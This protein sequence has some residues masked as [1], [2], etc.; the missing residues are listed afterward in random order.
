[1]GSGLDPLR[2]NAMAGIRPA[3]ENP[4][5]LAAETK[6]RDDER[7]RAFLGKVE[8]RLVNF[9]A[10][11]PQASEPAR[12]RALVDAYLFGAMGQKPARGLARE[13]QRALVAHSM[14][15]GAGAE[16]DDEFFAEISTRATKKK[17][18]LDLWAELSTA[19]RTEALEVLGG[20]APLGYLHW[21]GKMKEK[22]GFRAD[23]QADYELAWLEERENF[24]AAVEPFAA[25]VKEVFKGIRS[26]ESDF[27][28][29]F[30]RI[31]PDQREGFKEALAAVARTLPADERPT[32]FGNLAKQAGRDLSAM[33]GDALRGVG[34]SMT[35]SEEIVSQGSRNYV[36][37]FYRAMG[38]D[39]LADQSR[40]AFA[41]GDAR[42]ATLRER[43]D[44]V[45]DVRRIAEEV[46]DPVIPVTDGSNWLTRAVEMGAYAAPGAIGTT[47]T[48][49]I[50]YA[51]PVA[52]FGMI[53]EDSYRQIRGELLRGGATE[54]QARKWAEP[55]SG[56]VAVP[57][58]ALERLGAAAVVGKLPRVNA[59]LTKLADKAGRNAL[60]RGTVRTIGGGSFETAIELTQDMM[61]PLAI[62]TAR[63]LGGDL[64]G[65]EWK[66]GKDG[67]LDDYWAKTTTT[68]VAILP[69]AILGA[70]GG[71]MRDERNRAFA[72]ASDLEL[73]AL[74][75]SETAIAEIRAAEGYQ[76][77]DAAVT[78]AVETADATTETAIDATQELAEEIENRRKALEDAQASGV[79]PIFREV[80]GEWSVTDSLTGQEIGRAPNHR[81]AIRLAAAKTLALDL[82][83]ADAVEQ[84]RID[85]LDSMLETMEAAGQEGQAQEFRPGER[86]T[87]TQAAAESVGA[88]ERIAWQ[89]RTRETVETGDSAMAD[90][91]LGSSAVEV[92]DGVRRSVNRL[93]QGA[94]ALTVLHEKTHVDF[95]RALESGA[96][97]Q[98]ETLR[99]VRAVQT[100]L[101]SRPGRKG[102]GETLA[103]HYLPADD[104]AVTL[105]HLDEAVAELV[106]AEVLRTRKQGGG[107]APAAVTRNLRAIGRLVGGKAPRF[108]AFLRAMRDHFG[109]VFKRAA[110]V[111]RALRTGEIDRAGYEGFLA[112]LQGRE[113]QQDL[114]QLARDAEA[115]ILDGE[116]DPRELSA[117]EPFSVGSSPITAE[118][119]ANELAGR[120]GE[121]NLRLEQPRVSYEDKRQLLLDFAKSITDGDSGGTGQAVNDP[122][123]LRR[124]QLIRSRLV[125]KVRV[126]L[127]VRFIGDTIDSVE[128]LVEKAQA[129][130][131]PGFETFYLLAVDDAGKLLD[132]MAI[133][134]RCPC[135]ARIGYAEGTSWD[136]SM[137]QHERFLQKTGAAGY[138]LLHNHPSG[139]PSPSDADQRVTARHAAHFRDKYVFKGHVV[140]NHRTFTVI[141]RA[142]NPT[143]TRSLDGM[144][145]RDPL[146]TD[147]LVA[148]QFNSPQIVAE[149]GANWSSKE[150]LSENE[151]FAFAL[152]PR[153]KLVA[154]YRATLEDVARITA[155]EGREQG[156][157]DGTTALVIYS[158]AADRAAAGKKL[159]EISDKAGANV[160]AE[161]VISYPGGGVLSAIEVGFINYRDGFNFGRQTTGERV[162]EDSPAFS[163]GW[164]GVADAIRGDA[165]GR[166]KN[167][168]R[169]AEA[170]RRVA[171]A[172]A[173][174]KAGLERLEVRVGSRR[175]KRSLQNEMKMRQALRAEELEMDAMRKHLG[176]L[177]APEES[178][179][180]FEQPVH[181]ALTTEKVDKNGRKYRAGR[182][183]S[184]TAAVKRRPELFETQGL[185]G[186]YDGSET[187]HRGLF[188]G[189]MEPDVLAQELFNDGL[190]PEPFAD[191]MW[192]A[193]DREAMSVTNAKAG[194]DAAKAAIAEAKRQAAREAKEWMENAL[195]NQAVHFSPAE[196]IR[197]A[198]ALLDGI[199]NVVPAEIRGKVGGYTQLARLGGEET[200]L[201]FLRDRLA[202]VDN[203]L[204]RWLR[205]QYDREFRALLER[206]RPDK[207]EA[208]KRP[209][210]KAGANVHDLFR[211]IEEAMKWT[212]AEAEAEAVK[213]ETLVAGGELTPEEEAHF[214]LTANLLPMVAEWHKADAMRRES[215]VIEATKV[216]QDGYAKYTIQVLKKREARNRKRA[217]L[218]R[219]AGG[220]TSAQKRRDKLRE[221]ATKTGRSLDAMLSLLSFEQVV[222]LA[223]GE[224]STEGNM[225]VDWERAAAARKFD[226]IA[227]AEDAVD[228]LLADLGGGKYRG[229]ELRH[230]LAHKR[231]V[232]WVD[233]KGEK[234]S[235]SELEAITATLMWRQ[236]DGRRH[237]EGHLDDSGAPV[238]E[239]HWR[240]VDIDAIENQLSDA[241]KAIRLHLSESYAAEYSRLNPIFESLYGVS[242][243]RHK[244]YSPLSVK[245]VQV[246]AG[247]MLDP[248]SGMAMSGASMTPG[249]LRN[250]MTA[251]VAEPDFKD[252]LQHYLAHVRQ[253]EHWM[254][255]APFVQEAMAVV[256]QRDVGNAVEVKAGQ[257]TL[258]V[259][260]GWLDLFGAGGVRDAAGL[261][262]LSNAFQRIMSQ[263]SAA[264][265]VG[266]VSVLAIQSTQLGAAQAE[267]PVGAYVTRL[268][269]LLSGQLDWKAAMKSPFIQRRIKT[270]PPAVRQAM[271]G[272]TAEAPNRLKYAV[273][274]MGETIGGAD[275]LFTS[276]TYAIIFDY[277][278]KQAMKAGVENPEAAAAEVAERL[279]ERVAQPVRMGT[280]S[281]FENQSTNPLAR[282]MWAFSS[283]PRQKF[284]LIAYRL[285]LAK[286]KGNTLSALKE[287]R[288]WRAAAVTWLWGGVFASIIRAAMRDVRDDEDDEWFDERN[289]NPTRMAVASLSGPLYGLPI[290]G[291]EL[292]SGMM[293]L[294]DERPFE[295][296]LF[297]GIS[298]GIRS[299]KSLLNGGEDYGMEEALR[300]LESIAMASAFISETGAAAT[301]IMHVVRDL[302]GIVTNAFGGEDEAGAE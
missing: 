224:N 178:A 62:E 71:R 81:G 173:E 31:D 139:D 76:S 79:L 223:F 166:I 257:E 256:N 23:Y 239:W 75:L 198:L 153:L 236:E 292:E 113:E 244:D 291:K 17:A 155:Q 45:D 170:M 247:Q 287:A 197:R 1:M 58:A 187:A 211:R 69:L 228:N 210:G 66:N 263:L 43:L 102:T 220:D 215:A 29:V 125:E 266:R 59:L 112:K 126:D 114:E 147:F 89:A 88:E 148:R 214:L 226:S 301:S 243:P 217:A 121:E 242:L 176:A 168:M 120:I 157:R 97:T 189:S 164:S 85:Y 279:V 181:A 221:G 2:G 191:A 90:L 240:Q 28:Q 290:V 87:T 204:E 104:A 274:K 105:E 6:R 230:A 41:M 144:Q 100:V 84:A 234:Q 254:A 248:V 273:R 188:G 229:E 132:A 219:D 14:F 78:A 21:M 161:I 199:L 12:K 27:S 268:A 250:R 258:K 96:L 16:S 177:M 201:A 207:D 165:I 68:F 264:A 232:E 276:G 22:P 265:L 227:A 86:I 91:V 70:A 18:E 137:E 163:V 44:F 143:E 80:D 51:G 151:V 77:L 253:M 72:G 106:E 11:A 118:T 7:R 302:Y 195:E 73:K 93:N 32:F 127:Q 209:V 152:D 34:R 281:L 185:G 46:Y 134:G 293:Y 282:A 296:T 297:S 67:V 115:R 179:M 175:L 160:L 8:S 61:N 117:I 122:R 270:M 141:D 4:L 95:R 260:R 74:G 108:M 196:E 171:E 92:V 9:E 133:T 238:G 48:A 194:M 55:L 35:G 162:Q 109:L 94:S 203:E 53:R 255:Y 186:H 300:D 183:M 252:A 116:V 271:E 124:L 24:A 123:G 284:A 38:A 241:A 146:R 298:Q 47:L 167:P 245:P 131:N 156:E 288:F 33:P 299:T 42:R 142:G 13:R 63:A 289:W 218:Q 136:E 64:P 83:S 99:V 295:G 251:G 280:R 206:A 231:R 150:G 111:N 25:E 246:Q 259:L 154:L 159:I 40:E 193:L 60:A 272:L 225:L 130:R 50:P 205:A 212:A 184:K 37:E 149:F 119:L 278:L 249:S 10:F 275:A 107:L 52:S 180:L 128:T 49:L 54:E 190:I 5:D 98:A 269:K 233:F 294:A 158:E 26:G 174:A 110:A 20:G 65:V 3:Y 15:G 57:A 235:L 135:S 286:Q 237:M 200:R 36:D 140:I 267:M 277:Q 172:M 202:R 283:E 145:T 101:E 261:L 208:G 39:R 222:G 169:R 19:A 30:D 285:M 192:A 138:Y 262:K 56:V 182:I 103:F 129:L 216:F 213:L 82:E